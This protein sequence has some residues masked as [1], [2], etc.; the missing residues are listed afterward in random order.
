MA[1]L[2]GLGRRRRRRTLNAEV[3]IINLVDVVLVLLIIFMVTAPMM[4]GG[5]EV[6]LPKAATTPIAN[7]DALTVSITRDGR[8]RGRGSGA[9]DGR[10]PADDSRHRAAQ[11]AEG[12]LHSR[13]C[14]QPGRRHCDRPRTGPEDRHQLGGDRRGA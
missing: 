1:G 5:I 8:G 10:L 7:R 4:Q 2:G 12:D 6:R 14:R 13:R 3:N 9:L 11:G